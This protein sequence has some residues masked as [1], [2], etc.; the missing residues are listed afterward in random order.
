MFSK[1][2]FFVA[3]FFGSVEVKIFFWALRAGDLNF[4]SVSEVCVRVFENESI[5]SH[6]HQLRRGTYYAALLYGWS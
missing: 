3:L 5:G 2:V 4:R 1:C 6:C